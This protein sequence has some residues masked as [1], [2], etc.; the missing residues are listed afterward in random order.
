MSFSRIT[1]H[2]VDSQRSESKTQATSIVAIACVVNVHYIHRSEFS[3]RLMMPLPRIFKHT[4]STNKR[5][6]SFGIATT[7]VPNGAILIHVL[8]LLSTNE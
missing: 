5:V 7:V 1:K 3:N 2:A 6:K 4:H 8:Q